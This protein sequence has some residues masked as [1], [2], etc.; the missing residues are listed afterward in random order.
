MSTLQLLEEIQ[1]LGVKL[2]LE[3]GRL[4]FSAPKGVITPELRQQLS[5]RK[6]EITNILFESSVEDGAL[7]RLEAV[8][9]S[10]FLPLSYSQEALWFIDQANPGD[11]VYNMFDAVRL[12]GALRV[13]ALERAIRE[14]VKRHEA[15]RTN[16]ASHKGQPSQSIMPAGAFSLTRVDLRNIPEGEREVELSRL[17]RMEVQRPFELTRG[18]LFR[19]SLFQLGDEHHL[20]LLTVHHAISDGWSLAIIRRELSVLYSCFCEGKPSPLEDLSIQ[21][22][23]FAIWQRKCLESEGFKGH[24]AYW[25]QRL[26]DIPVALELPTDYPRPPIQTFCGASQSFGIDP[27]LCEALG[28][29]GKKHRCS[30]FMMLLAVFKILLYR[31]SDQE[32]IVVGVPVSGRNRLETEGICGFFV[33]MLALRTD[34]S[35][36]PAFAE[37]LD[38]LREGFMDAFSHQDVPFEKLVAELQ[39]KRDKSRN[40]IFQVSFSFDPPLPEFKL[41]GLEA[42]AYDVE[43]GASHF[44]LIFFLEESKNGIR[45][46]VEYNTDLFGSATIDR[47]VG[48]YLR[49]M[50]GIVENPKERISKLP[51]LGGAEERTIVSAWNETATDYPR[52]ACVHELFE[53][54]A[55]KTPDAVALA[56]GSLD[57]GGQA[58]GKLTY[59]ELNR[60]ANKLAHHLEKLG[61]GPEVCV[62]VFMKRSMD[63]VAA[64]LAILKAGGAYVPLDPTYPRSRIAFML[65]DTGA[66]VLVTQSALA[67]DLPEYGGRIIRLDTDWKFI[68]GEGDGNCVRRNTAESLAYVIYTSG[69]TGDPK[70]VCVV[71]RGVVR[72]VRNTNYVALSGDEVFLQ[73]APISFDASTFEIWASLLNGARLV[74]FPPHLPTLEEL[75]SVLRDYG[76]TTLWLTA[77]LFHEMVD[78]RI[79]DLRGLRQ[80]LAGGEALSVP[81]VR[82]ALE[83]LPSTR[84]ING[85]GPTENTTFTCCHGITPESAVR[86]VP[87]GRPISN[88]RT[89]ILDRHLQPVPIGVPGEMYTGGDGLARGY[90]NAPEL[91]AAKF[92]QDPF[93][94]EAGGKLYRVGD[95]VRYL[96]SGEIE[97]LGRTDNQVKIRGFRI[98]LGEIENTLNGYAGVQQAVV[99][100]RKDAQGEKVLTA[101]VV[102]HPQREL[103]V[104]GLRS[105]LKESLP[106]YMVP[107]VFVMV[108]GIPRT[109]NGKVDSQA[110]PEPHQERAEGDQDYVAPGT[111]TEKEIC[112]IWAE[113]LGIERVG[114]HDDFFDLG[115][116][117]LLVLRAIT[118]INECLGSD[119]MPVALFEHPT[120]AGLCHC[121]DADRQT[122]A[123][124]AQ[125][126]RHAKSNLLGEDQKADLAQITSTIANRGQQVLLKNGKRPY[127]MR[128]SLIC[129]WILAPMFR[130]ERR[131]VRS[132]LQFLI[133][134]LE[135]GAIFTVTLR[136]LYAKYFDLHIGDY[137]AQCFDVDR[138]QEKTRIGRYTGIYPTVMIRNA[139]HPRN[140]ISTHGIF[141]HPAFQFQDE[142]YELTRMQ[143]EIGNDVFIGHN[144]TIL[145]PTRKIG[146][147]AVIAAG[148]VV[149]ED[150]PPYAIVGGYPAKILRYRFSKERI[151]ELLES[152][153]WEASLEELEPVREQFMLPLE[154]GK[155]I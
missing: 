45:G 128:E 150:V 79:E 126:V 59:R 131:S 88:T 60:R 121:L 83:G 4:R 13:D 36:D 89:Y 2:W 90:L 135:G 74:I 76:V 82:R 119:L 77:S 3:D 92:I 12:R 118:A 99:L 144:A 16:F 142:G 27:D 97:F 35:G 41:S 51:L 69:S 64:I 86:S 52:D 111:A 124:A 96:P 115:G 53:E 98:E 31:Y 22:A 149:V 104:A 116:H 141:Y 32:D 57:T 148:S 58:E 143:V 101:Y 8:S 37:L 129:R 39:P 113:V 134:K 110:L 5:E 26:Q 127:R 65:K 72:L 91:T 71:H 67:N 105:F 123:A 108:D 23:D 14:L 66:P 147:G 10:D 80:L 54:Q 17:A 55:E 50:Q 132:L 56:M 49:L 24:M 19:A 81:H 70:G 93:S 95:V 94:N 75:G 30:L 44:D 61:I 29:I 7:P 114:V 84:L 25:K 102:A 63:T 15:L 155:I 18:M 20:L 125:Q 122:Q 139:N 151:Q 109:A 40:P 21:Y 43:Y 6:S 146:D 38:R 152:K 28:E 34:L 33:N 47:L 78:R 103:T 153:W 100:V 112:R 120:V 117:S 145:F 138:M 73:F 130:I 85:Y 68:D 154:G 62:G 11:H 106:D 133:L 42:G 1:K 140:T 137:S 48:H 87:I 9:R 136:K 107:S 46:K